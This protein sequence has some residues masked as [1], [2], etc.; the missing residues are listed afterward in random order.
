MAKRR[1][2]TFSNVVIF[3]VLALALVG[4]VKLYGDY[5][6]PVFER[7]E[8]VFEK[9][10]KLRDQIAELRKRIEGTQ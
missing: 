1:R 9:A 4:F 10:A 8:Q 6:K 5:S 2:S 3:G 7:S